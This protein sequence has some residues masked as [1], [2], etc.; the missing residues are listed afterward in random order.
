MHVPWQP[1]W[2]S[3]DSFRCQALSHLAEAGSLLLCLTQCAPGWPTPE[4]LGGFPVSAFKLDM[5]EGDSRCGPLYLFAVVLYLNCLLG[6]FDMYK[7]F[8]CMCVYLSMMIILYQPSLLKV[9][10][11][12][13]SFLHFLF[14]YFFFFFVQNFMYY[15]LAWNLLYCQ[16]WP[17][18]PDSPDSSPLKG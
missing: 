13:L 4:L 7:C 16:R 8:A 15:N 3:E 14:L 12:S 1:M 6:L 10:S 5:G 9:S 18:I 2:S 17:W 11:P